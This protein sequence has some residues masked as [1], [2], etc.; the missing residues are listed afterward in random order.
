MPLTSKFDIIKLIFSVFLQILYNYNN[1]LF[2]CQSDFFLQET[3]TIKRKLEQTN[4]IIEDLSMPELVTDRK[5]S[6]KNCSKQHSKFVN[7][8]DEKK[9]K[10]NIFWPNLIKF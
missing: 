10:M 3:L 4:I 9:K 2:L 8:K 1:G 5:I 6:V 7:S